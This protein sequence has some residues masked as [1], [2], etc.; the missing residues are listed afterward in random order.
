MRYHLFRLKPPD[1]YLKSYNNAVVYRDIVDDVRKHYAGGVYQLKIIDGTLI[2]TKTFEIVGKP[3]K[4]PYMECNCS[5]VD[6]FNYG[7]TCGG[8]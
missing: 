4:Y 1:G 2:K 7:C 3:S 8:K 6:L 5:A